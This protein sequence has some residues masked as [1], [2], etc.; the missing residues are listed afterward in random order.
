MDEDDEETGFPGVRWPGKPRTEPGCRAP[1]NPK[2]G[3]RPGKPATK[4][5]K[6]F[7]RIRRRFKE[8]TG[9]SRNTPPQEFGSLLHKLFR[10][11]RREPALILNQLR[12]HWTA[13][14]GTEMGSRTRPA[15]LERGTLW[16]ETPDACWAYELQ[17]FKQDLLNSIEAFIKS[18]TVT[19]LR[20]SVTREPPN[21]NPAQGGQ[22]LPDRPPDDPIPAEPTVP[23]PTVAAP[24]VPESSMAEPSMAEP[25]MAEPTVPEPSMAEPTGPEP[26]VPEPSMAEPS[27]DNWDGGNNDGRENGG[28]KNV[29]GKNS[30]RDAF[31]RMRAMREKT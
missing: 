31:Q 14:A 21:P 22:G 24:S 10:E 6:A 27:E 8:E 15:K 16:V 7:T 29:G 23:E 17:F 1:G 2:P 19:G 25:S 26:T 11:H 30:V 9:M 13:I 28:G 18:S 4:G 3:A 12:E 5:E 20:F